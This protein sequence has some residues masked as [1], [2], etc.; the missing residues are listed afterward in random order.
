MPDYTVH[1]AAM[2]LIPKFLQYSHL[3][4]ILDN[5]SV[6]CPF[7][8]TEPDRVGISHG[9]DYLK[10]QGNIIDLSQ[11]C[12]D[13]MI[14]L[15]EDKIS[16]RDPVMQKCILYMNHYD[17][18]MLTFGQIAGAKYWGSGGDDQIDRAGFFVWRKKDMFDQSNAYFLAAS[19]MSDPIK[20]YKTCETL[21][22]D[23]YLTYKKDVDKW[24]RS[25]YFN[26]Y[27]VLAKHCANM[28]QRAIAYGAM[29]T[30]MRIQLAYKIVR[31]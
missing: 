7:Y 12:F 19:K 1:K 29:L 11:K 20:I 24:K 4:I 5:P 17:V 6:L 28:I 8:W 27:P 23:T 10:H 21:I 26:V 16:I 3:L 30:A 25:K 13:D 2:E 31:G 22:A 18:D 14:R 9:Y 15:L